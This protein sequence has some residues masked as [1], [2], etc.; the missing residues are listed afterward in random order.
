MTSRA[1]K[2]ASPGREDAGELHRRV[3]EKVLLKSKT[4]N[5]KDAFRQYDAERSGHLTVAQFRTLM[6]DHGFIGGDAERLAKFLDPEG[7][8]S[9]SFN[10]FVAGARL[11]SEQRYPKASPKKAQVAPPLTSKADASPKN[12][13]AMGTVASAST[14]AGPADPIEQIRGRLRQRVMGHNKSIREVFLEFDDDASGFLDY[15][16]FQRFMA[17]YSFSPEETQLVIEFLDRDKSG[18]IDYDEFSAGLLFYRPP[19]AASPVHATGFPS[20]AT[21]T[22]PTKPPMSVTHSPPKVGV[23]KADTSDLL[24]RIR[25]KLDE[26]VDTQRDI[27]REQRIEILRQAFAKCDVDGNNSLDFQEFGAFLISIGVKL[28]SDELSTLFRTLDKDNS[29]SVEL[30][31][32]LKASRISQQ[33]SQQSQPSSSSAQEKKRGKNSGRK[34]LLTMFNKYDIDGSGRLDYDEF[35]QLMRENG[36]SEGEI[37]EVIKQIDQDQIKAGGQTK[38]SPQQA[39]DFD[40]FASAIKARN[41]SF[42]DRKRINGVADAKKAG[43]QLPVSEAT[44]SQ[45]MSRVMGQNRS[46][47][48]AFSQHD[49]DGSGELDVDEF[50]RFMKH[51][52]MK[53]SEDIDALVEYIDTDR[54]GFIS[55]AEFSRAFG[56]SANPSL[57]L[58]KQHRGPETA[59]NGQNGKNEQAKVRLEALKEQE[60]AFMRRAMRQHGSME[61]TFREHDRDGS[62]ELDYEEFREMMDSFGINDERT[63]SMLLKKLDVD[64]SGAIDIDEFLALFNPQRLKQRSDGQ[65]GTKSKTHRKSGASMNASRLRYLAQMWRQNA[66]QEYAT[67]ENAF[68]SFSRQGN[69]TLSRDDFRELLSAFGVTRFEE[70][71]ALISTLDPDNSGTIYFDEFSSIFDEQS[72]FAEPEETSKTSNPSSRRP[73]NAGNESGR[74]RRTPRLREL[75]VKWVQRALAC[76][77]SI[78]DAFC[79]YDEDGNGALDHEEFQSVMKRYGIVNEADID[80]LIDVLDVDESG[81]IDFAEFS[82]VFHPA[83]LPPTRSQPAIGSRLEEVD[84]L[85]NAD[86]LE[87]VLEIERDLA[88]RIAQQSRDLRLA[89]RKFDLNG[90]GQLEYK[91]FRAVLK[92]FRLPEMEIRKVIRHLDR[93]VSGFI[94]YKEFIAGFSLTSDGNAAVG[95]NGR[96]KSGYAITR[97]SPAKPDGQRKKRSPKKPN[98]SDA[99]YGTTGEQDGDLQLKKQMLA[100]ILG[101]HGTVQSVFRHYDAD[102]VGYL[103]PAQFTNLA[104]DFKFSRGQA[105]RLQDVLD[106][107]GSGSIEY[108]EFLSQLVI[109]EA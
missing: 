71:E 106:R 73:S 7:H 79:Q 2:G 82:T 97:N 64:N 53:R 54:S 39:I 93:D 66:L 70:I 77:P 48:E 43:R 12:K 20:S 31:E 83:R 15:G 91:E 21:K 59:Q 17:R 75:E 49:T 34:E 74:G 36:F 44:L 26:L 96:K 69:G 18:T 94:D 4:H 51:Y 57:N 25:G 37:L 1:S 86:E 99:N 60:L 5:I 47:E 85:F 76:H 14:A 28:R 11:S 80:T 24:L 88:K 35:G 107:D 9:I 42:G 56:R 41:L 22:S 61:A 68:D 55:F 84:E 30:D 78:E 72:P 87:S 50:R 32:F 45:W 19:P 108:E 90:N 105:K 33:S 95:G 40:T 81:A 102:Q 38:G 101:T 16:E 58:K 65:N 89:F 52:G 67:V 100:R 62:D 98:E 6:R 10:A 103:T 109:R 46:L 13:A 3:L 92:S 63:V 27:Q 23:S 29:E 104:T 8:Q